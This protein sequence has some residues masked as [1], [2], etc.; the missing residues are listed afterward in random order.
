MR[1]ELVII[2]WE[3]GCDPQGNRARLLGRLTDPDL[4][5]EAKARVVA[6][7][8]RDLARLDGPLRLAPQPPESHE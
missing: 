5:Q 6:E 3:D 1:I 4:L 7:R 2:G 8:R